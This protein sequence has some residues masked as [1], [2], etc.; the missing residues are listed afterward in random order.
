MVYFCKLPHTIKSYDLLCTGSLPEHECKKQVIEVM[1]TLICL[2]C[3]SYN[4]KAPIYCPWYNCQLICSCEVEWSLAYNTWL[5]DASDRPQQSRP[6][7][8]QFSREMFSPRGVFMSERGGRK[9]P[10]GMSSPTV[11]KQEQTQPQD[12]S[13]HSSEFPHQET[14]K[15]EPLTFDFDILKNELKSTEDSDYGSST[16]QMSRGGMWFWFVRIMSC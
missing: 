5:Q 4:D 16:P 7:V 11:V 8:T 14:I 13:Q 12:F 15:A 9:Q 10:G 1:N 6:L 2:L 3:P